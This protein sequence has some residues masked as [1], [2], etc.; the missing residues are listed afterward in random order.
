MIRKLEGYYYDVVVCDFF[1]DG[2]L[3]V[4]VFYDIRVYIWDSY[5]G[6]IL[7]EFGWV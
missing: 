7:M 1:F 5:I 3:L 6:G 4:I 2:V